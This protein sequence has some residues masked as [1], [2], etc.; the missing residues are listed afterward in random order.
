M[1]EVCW[2]SETGGILLG[3]GKEQGIGL[4]IR[5]VFHEEL[6]LLRFNRH[7]SYPENDERPLLWATSVSRRYFYKGRLV[8]EIKG[9]GF[10]EEPQIHFYEKELKLDPVDVARMVKK[11]SAILE[12]M[13]QQAIGFILD[14]NNQYQKKTDITAVAFSG[15]K[16]SLVLLDLVQRTLSPDE[17]VVVFNDTTMEISATHESVNKAREKW[18][19]LS[20]YTAKA[21]KDALT[22]WKEFG[23]PSRIHRWCCTVHK[24]APTLLLLRDLVGKP[25]IKALIFDGIRQAESQ[26]RSGYKAVTEGGKHGSQ[27]NASPIILWNSAEVFLYLFNRNIFY[28]RAYIKG[29]T[30]VGCNVCPFSS[31]WS[32][33]IYKKVYGLEVSEFLNILIEYAQ[34]DNI[35]QSEIKKYINERR[36]KGRAGGRSLKNGKNKIQESLNNNYFSFTIAQPTENWE[37][38]IKSIG[39]VIKVNNKIYIGTKTLMFCY[40]LVR[41][42]DILN[43]TI[44]GINIS[45]RLIV[46]YIRCVN[47]KT[48]YCVHCRGCEPECPTG[49]LT[50]GGKIL[51]DETKCIHCGKCLTFQEKG[52]LAARSLSITKKGATMKGMNR[53]QTFGM[54]TEWLEEF[55]RKQ[56]NWW[57]QNDLGNRQF[58]AMKVWLIEAELIDKNSIS[59]LGRQLSALGSD[60]TLCWA[61]IWTNWGR[62]SAL[63]N[64][65]QTHVPWKSYHS[66]N[67]LAELVGGDLSIRTRQNAMKSLFLLL[68]ESPLGK[69]MGLGEIQTGEQRIE[70]INKK[71][72][73][74]PDPIAVLYSLYRY[75]EKVEKQN[76]TVSELYDNA[77]EGPYVLFGIEQDELKRILR[78]LASSYEKW[79]SVELMRDLD[80][81]NLDSS[82]KAED[83][84]KIK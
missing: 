68:R 24:S 26:A 60:N 2:D 48:A 83:I 80:N 64:W 41:V 52:C 81:I 8:A 63:I 69:E 7:W 65:Y 17:F 49:A 31:K 15:G 74:N 61:I 62:N 47:Y 25:A 10:F 4:E 12:G 56:Q 32:E 46:Q 72:W 78:G 43:V 27:V 11:N 14:V 79:I 37:E 77:P 53:Y 67:E 1:Y 51:I 36:W 57:D 66:K 19:N 82:I 5:P 76:L 73:D 44:T 22:T 6:N 21:A 20:F 42:D 18:D 71:G 50:V 13:A 39:R 30:R 58:D 75:A 33:L 45:D 28:N 23:P 70:H 84:L 34:N 9:G 54:K 35:E 29:L 59:S 40:E 55:F 3:C 38:W 16:D